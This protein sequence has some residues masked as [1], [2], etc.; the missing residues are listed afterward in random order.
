M[1][2]QEV[3]PVLSKA[4]MNKNDRI[5]AE[6]INVLLEA[7]TSS[8]GQLGSITDLKFLQSETKEDNETNFFDN[9]KHIQKHRYL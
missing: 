8:T 1:I 9:M 7:M 5:Q 3:L 2:D 4:L 6:F